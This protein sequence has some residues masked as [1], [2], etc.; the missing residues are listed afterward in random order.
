MTG[1][2]E[3]NSSVTHF[4]LTDEDKDDKR[5]VVRNFTVTNR[6]KWPVAVH[7]IT[8]APEAARFFRMTSSLIS[9]SNKVNN[10]ISKLFTFAPIVLQPGET[11]DLISLTLK[12]EAWNKRILNSHLVI[13]TNISAM[14][15][16]LVCFH[17]NVDTVRFFVL[18]RLWRNTHW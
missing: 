13:H 14:N 6:F 1:E 11:K 12:D 16:P 8:L 5:T 18:K 10:K 15:V 7:D 4:H 9:K 2:L 17:G 3:V